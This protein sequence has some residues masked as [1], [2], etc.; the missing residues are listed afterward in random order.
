[1]L[2]IKNIHKIQNYIFNNGLNVIKIVEDANSYVFC[3]EREV[4]VYNPYKFRP[5]TKTHQT[6]VVLNRTKDISNGRYKIIDSYGN[7]D[8]IASTEIKMI[9]LFLSKFEQ[10]VL[11]TPID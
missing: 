1:M 3:I 11:S 7:W 5:E 9:S 10:F 2:D 6:E 8:F 4:K